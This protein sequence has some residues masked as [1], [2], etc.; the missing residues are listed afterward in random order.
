MSP[1]E[2]TEIQIEG[3]RPSPIFGR[4]RAELR[5]LQS[6]ITIRLAMFSRLLAKRCRAEPASFS[7]RPSTASRVPVSE[8][9]HRAPIILCD[10]DQQLQ[11]VAS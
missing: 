1:E 4:L 3:S 5:A 7:Q 6:M 2:F 10:L 11:G 8:S 9:P